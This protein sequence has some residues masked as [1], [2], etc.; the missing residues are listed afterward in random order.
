VFVEKTGDDPLVLP[1]RALGAGPMSTISR[2]RP[3]VSGHIEVRL[4]LHG[5][6]RSRLAAKED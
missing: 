3:A 4:D 6:G 5:C 1:V 2:L